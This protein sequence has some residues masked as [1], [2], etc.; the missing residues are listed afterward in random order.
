MDNEDLLTRAGAVLKGMSPPNTAFITPAPPVDMPT[1][2]ALVTNF[3]AAITAAEDGGKVAITAL[4]K[5]RLQVIHGLKQLGAYVE[6]NCNGDL[7][8]F[9][10]S[11]FPAVSNVRKP[12]VP[13]TPATVRKVKNGANSGQLMILIAALIAALSYE[14]RYAAVAGG[15]PGAWTTVTVTK[16]RAAVSITGLTPGTS[17][18]F[19]VRALG[20]LG[21]TDWS[22]S[23]TQMCT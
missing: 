10:S 19:Q 7:A 3:G 16:V 11:G 23:V 9:T 4:G 15:V 14:L 1:F 2:G 5:I 8:I 20:K 12:A 22:D 6:A 13:L 17:Y 21:F 18:A